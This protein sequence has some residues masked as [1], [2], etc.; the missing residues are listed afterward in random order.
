MKNKLYKVNRIWHVADFINLHMDKK[1]LILNKINEYLESLN[2]EDRIS[3]AGKFLPKKFMLSS[4]F[5]AQ[6]SI[7]L[8]LITRFYP[9]IPIVLIDTGYL[10]PETYRFVDQLKKEM[11]L[12]LYVFK[13]NQSPAWQEARYGKLWEQGIT[14]ISKYNLINKIKPMHHALKKLKISTWFSGLRRTQ[15]NS[16][17]NL[18]IIDIKH[19]IFKFLPIIDWSDQKIHQYMDQNRLPYNPLWKKGYVSIGDIHTTKKKEFGMKDEDTRFFGLKR[20]CGL[21]Q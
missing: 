2:A 3:W 17:M 4:S 10:F 12:N 13:S 1:K 11:K 8:H 21:H 15:S 19:G 20:E 7:S 18:P 16:R 14:G 6:S 9:K 5:G